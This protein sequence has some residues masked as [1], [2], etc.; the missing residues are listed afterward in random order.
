MKLWYQSWILTIQHIQSKDNIMR[1][2][3]VIESILHILL[4]INNND[5][6]VLKLFL[7]NWY[8]VSNF[9]SSREQCYNELGSHGIKFLISCVSYHEW[10]HMITCISCD[11]LGTSYHECCDWCQAFITKNLDEIRY[12]YWQWLFIEVNVLSSGFYS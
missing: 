8:S 10:L 5:I 9:A 2:K 11:Y 7:V 1:Y 4:N 12:F 6:V 3:L